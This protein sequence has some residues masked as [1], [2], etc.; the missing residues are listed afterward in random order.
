LAI[1]GAAE[2]GTWSIAEPGQGPVPLPAGTTGANNLSGL[3]WI[4]GNQWVVVADKGGAAYPLEVVLDASGRIG[5]ASL[6]AAI[7]LAGAVDAEGIAWDVDRGTLFVSDETGPAIREHVLAS[8]AAVQSL[9]LPA[10]YSQARS[11]LSLESLSRDPVSRSLWTAN[12]EA[13]S[14]DGP[15]S[16]FVD[17][18]LVRLQRFDA[19][20]APA[21]QWAWRTDPIEANYGSPGRDVETS[22]VSD[23]VALPDGGLLVLERSSGGTGL[24]SRLYLAD[25]SGADDTSALAALAGASFAPVAKSLRWSRNFL[26]QNFEGAALGPALPGGGRSLLLVSDDGSG[27]QQTLLALVVHDGTCGDAFVDPPEEQC[28]DGNAD[29]GDGCTSACLS[30]TCGDGL[31]NDGGVEECDDGNL[32]SGDGCGPDCRLEKPQ[33]ACRDAIRKAATDYAKQRRKA[34]LRCRDQLNRGAALVSAAD[35]PAPL[36][37]P[38]ACAGEGDAA[39]AISRAAAKL[40]SQVAGG[41]APRCSDAVLASLDA[42]APTV[43]GLVA[44]DGRSGC[45]VSSHDGAVD[46][47]VDDEYGRRLDPSETALRKC[48]ETIAKFSGKFAETREKSILGCRRSLL[49]GRALFLDDARTQRLYDPRDCASEASVRAKVGAAAASIRSKAVSI[50]GCD[51]GALASLADACGTTLDGIATTSGDAGCLVVG[52]A[53]AGDALLAAR[54]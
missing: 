23:L 4:S 28:D 44:P 18:T 19:G 6:G 1:A 42:C 20:F 40:R 29:D 52:H 25:F 30:E 2:A 34:L 9:A 10:V 24:R 47:M 16:G 39:E 37:D 22:G 54:P 12:E 5:S 8:G 41:A 11:N 31:L 27:L 50:G 15:V 46:A 38:S 14:V 49:S 13:L 17:G 45:I 48:Q 7:P 35:P 33:R 53:Q 36:L 43:D 51:D 32:A 26:F 21:G 3:A